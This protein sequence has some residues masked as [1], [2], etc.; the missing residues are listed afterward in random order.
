MID[1]KLKMSSGQMLIFLKIFTFVFI[2]SKDHAIHLIIELSE[3]THNL[4]CSDDGNFTKTET[5]QHL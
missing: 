1:N 5:E 3:I 2:S 4:F